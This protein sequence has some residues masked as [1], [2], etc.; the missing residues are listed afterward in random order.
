MFQGI[1]PKPTLLGKKQG[2][3]SQTR[4]VLRNAWNKPADATQTT[5]YRKGYNLGKH[6][7]SSGSD[8]ARFKRE[9]ATMKNYNDNKL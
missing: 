8:Y 2:E 6:E 1:S 5:P 3:E 4:Q 9:R 7:T